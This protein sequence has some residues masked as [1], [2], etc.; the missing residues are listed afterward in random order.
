MSTKSLE[1]DLNLTSEQGAKPD[2]QRERRA[3]KRHALDLAGGLSRDGKLF[4]QCRVRDFC[5]DGMMLE[6]DD[7]AAQEPVIGGKPATVG[8]SLVLQFATQT[9]GEQQKHLVRVLVA[10]T[11]RNS[12][13]VSFDGE[14]AAAIWQLRQL[15]RE[16]KDGLRKNRDQ[17]RRARAPSAPMA[18]EQALNA[19]QMLEVAKEHTEQFLIAGLGRLF[20]DA[21]NRLIGAASQDSNDT[22]K[23]Q[24]L[25]A[26]KE[27]QSIRVSVET[28]YLKAVGA[29]FDRMVNPSA[30]IEPE[31]SAG[32]QEL[33]LVDTGSFDDWLTT[34]NIISAAEGGL[35][36]AQYKLEQ[37][38]TH[39]V[40]SAIDEENNP[41]GLAQLCLT[42]HDAVQG[43]GASGLARRS[44]LEA[45]EQT[46]AARLGEFYG[47]LNT[48]FA[49]GGILPSV[50][51]AKHVIKSSDS[52]TLDPTNPVRALTA[53]AVHR[54]CCRH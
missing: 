7:G 45:F 9:N 30:A 34:K 2:S 52:T 32:E 1:S 5:A 28:A 18:V 24:P 15:V 23:A 54:P 41:I 6:F 20:E 42:F 37:R 21:E 40:R 14:N 19:S 36:E 25:D 22:R 38:L 51:R 49:N 17:A 47:D 10:R 3:H 12:I 44:I 29:E 27:V 13:G 11:M 16:L 46:I 53:S 31:E 8:D 4:C 26:M 50:E 33:A 35:K 43:L 39:L 48:M